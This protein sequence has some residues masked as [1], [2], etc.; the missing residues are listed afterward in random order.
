[1]KSIKIIFRISLIISLLMYPMSVS[2][3]DFNKAGRTALQFLKIGV[4]ARPAAMGEACVAN[5]NNV[6]AMFW[7]PAAIGQINHFE[8][9][10]SYTKWFADMDFTAGAVGLSVTS[11]M[12]VALD[13]I[14]LN[15]GNIPEALVTHP[16]GRLD[17]RTGENFSGSD[18]SLGVSVAKNFTNKL[19]IGIRGKYVQE[20]LYTYSTN[21]WAFDIGT[22][23]HTGWK[24]IRL[25][26]S[27]QNFAGKAR[28][29]A[30]LE[31]EKQ[32]Y[33]VPLLFRIGTSIDLLGG[34]D[35]FLGGNPDRHRLTL[36]LDAIH[37]NDYAE[38][39]N[40]GAEYWFFNRI[41]L[42]SGYRFNQSYGKISFG[43]ALNFPVNQTNIH[44]D[45]AYVDYD[46]LD[47]TH[48]FTVTF[49]Y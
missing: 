43:G 5:L 7:N 1:M 45:Y 27:A 15:Y 18:L 16:T 2:A 22:Y 9:S 4:G 30:T 32:Q 24:G 31:K 23:Y 3:G 38:R 28:W 26:M 37:S 12:V 29:L 44:I 46:Y 11:T 20:D 48:R 40:I 21:L 34:S 35:L 49:T 19:S 42:R 47:I 33:E 8:T 13:Y 6:N 10:F 41:A 36:N 14:S 17:T 25:A 39:L